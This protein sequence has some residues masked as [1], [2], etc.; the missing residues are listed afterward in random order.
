[1]G[2]ASPSLEA[3]DLRHPLN[4]SAKCFVDRLRRAAKH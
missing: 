2:L 1:M 3:L 4:E